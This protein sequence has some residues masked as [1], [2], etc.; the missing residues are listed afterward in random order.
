MNRK[1]RVV[2]FDAT[3]F[4]EVRIQPMLPQHEPTTGW[5]CRFCNSLFI[6]YPSPHAVGFAHD[7][8]IPRDLTLSDNVT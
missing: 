1:C 6:G 8:E 3:I 2:N 4:Q 5:R 7:C